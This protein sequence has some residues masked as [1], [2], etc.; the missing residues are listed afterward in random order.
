MSSTKAFKNFLVDLNS[1]FPELLPSSKL[2]E[3]DIEIFQK[4]FISSIIEILKKDSEL[5]NEPK[6]VFGLDLSEAFKTQPDLIWKYMQPC[7]FSSFLHGDIKSKITD[8]L[9]EL[10]NAFKDQLGGQNEI[11]ELLG[12]D[13]NKSKIGEFIDYLKNSKFASLMIAVFENIDLSDIDSS[14]IEEVLHNP[15]KLQEHPIVKRIQSQ[16]HSNMLNKIKNGELSKDSILQE[17][18]TLQTKI[19]EFFGDSLNEALGTQKSDVASEVLLS[20]SPE[21]RRARMVARLQRK[22][23]DRKK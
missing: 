11:D 23:K 7:L 16:I 17:F 18:Q 9:P 14:N 1:K 10:L 2:D 13:T 22:L 20:N 4:L 6:N 15:T 19:Q 21:A 5:F 8:T 12:D 3:N